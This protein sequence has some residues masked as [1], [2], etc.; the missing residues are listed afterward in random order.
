MGHEA[1]LPKIRIFIYGP[2]ALEFVHG[3]IVSADP[4]QQ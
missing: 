3:I 4:L 1:R 2:G